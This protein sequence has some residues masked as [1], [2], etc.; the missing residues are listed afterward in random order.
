MKRFCKC[1]CGEE[2]VKKYKGY[3]PRY[4]RGHHSKGINSHFYGKKPWNYGL[5]KETDERLLE[6]GKKSSKTL[7]RLFKEGKLKI[8]SIGL[9]K[10]T[11]KRLKN[12]G[13][14]QKGK[15]V[16]MET[17]KKQSITRKELFKEGKIDKSKLYFKKGHPPTR[18]SFKKNDP[19]LIGDKNPA[20]R[21][22]VREKIRLSKLGDKNP[23][24]RIEV[25]KH[26][27]E[28]NPNKNGKLFKNLE[29]LKKYAKSMNKRPN[30][31]EKLLINLLRQLKLP[32]KF[33]GDFSF[34]IEGK[35]PD[36]INVNDQKKII[37]LFGDYWHNEEKFP[38]KLNK[39]QL[40]KHYAK[41]GYKTLV[42]WEHELK[43][44]DKTLNRINE[45]DKK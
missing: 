10:E 16:S 23:M 33:V 21:P 4:I 2:I 18:G 19:R 26:M 42:I 22:E 28:N 9:T 13:E 31:K 24:K 14:K 1:G 29:Y 3:T 38:N 17:R 15:I 34:W 5:T 32:Y 44:L 41:Y 36:F 39:Q 35:N 20:K 8:W 37:E 30:K 11:D 12:F 45:F 27:I 40:K 7:K 43:D 6:Y 25:R